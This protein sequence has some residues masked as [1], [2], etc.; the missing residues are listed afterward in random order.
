MNIITD[1]NII[2]CISYDIDA[3]NVGKRIGK[4]WSDQVVDRKL[5][6]LPNF[7]LFCCG[8]IGTMRDYI[9]NFTAMK[10]IRVLYILL[11]LSFSMQMFPAGNMNF[12]F[13]KIQV[14]EGLSEN[15][16][17]C[18]LQDSK[19]F[20]W[21]G[22]KDGLNRYDG[23]NFR[24]FRHNVLN[25]SSLGNNFIRSMAEGTDG[26][27]Y[28]GTD[29]GLYI[30]DTVH[31]TFSF[32]AL[33]TLEG[34][35]LTTAVN[36]LFIDKDG[37]LWIGS[38]YQGTF[39]Y[40]PSKQTLRQVEV[41]EHNLGQNAV[42]TI[43]G[44]RS[45]TIWVGTRLG[46][47][48]YNAG[49]KELEAVDGLFSPLEN[50]D[51]EVL[52]I[53][54]DTKGCLWLGTWS[55][56]VRFYDRQRYY[57]TSY[58]GLQSETDYIT[59]VRALYQYDN[60]HI[61]IGSD[62]GLY[63]FD[64]DTKE[65]RR[66][67][68][69]QSHYSMSDQNVYS[70]ASDREGGIWIGTYFGGINYLDVFLLPVETYYA[71]VKHGM[72]SG[73]A[74]SQF[75]ED[76]K[77][78]MWI[79]TE[80]G[81]INYFD[82]RTKL[83]TQPIRTSYH[84]THAL[85]LDEDNLW[86]GT[87]SRGIDVYNTR[88]G[89]LVNYR[90]NVR[91]E[92]T[93]NDDCIFSLYRTKKGDIYAGTPVGLNKY[94]RQAD[95]F[96]RIN[97]VSGFIYDVKEDD[98]G[99][100]WVATYGNGVVRLDG[101]TKKWIYYDQVI[102]SDDPVVGS[103]LTSIYIDGQKRLI[104]SSE[105]RG[106]FI[107]DYQTDRFRNISETEGLPNNVVYGVLDDPFGNLWLSCNK[108]IVCLDVQTPAIHKVYNKEDG[109]QSNQFNYKSSYKTRD[110]K[111]YFGGI[112]GFSCFYPQDISQIQN[113]H[114]PSVEITDVRL[115]GN[116]RGQDADIQIL[117]NKQQR[118][119]FPY[120]K[121]SFTISY[122]SLSYQ[123][124]GKNE[125][126]YMLEGV[127]KDW[128]HAGNNK[129]VTYV[130]LRPG[131]YSF[132]VKASNNSGVWNEEGA[133]IDIEILP[134]F[135][136]SLPAKLLYLVLSI[137]LIY[138]L[139]S[140]F[141]K[142]HKEKQTQ[143]LYAYKTE[144]EKLAFKSKIDFFTNIAHE[145]RTPVSLIKAPLEEVV[146][147]G[148]GSEN[149][150]Q[151]LSVIEKNCNRLSVLI[152]QLL[153]FRKMD[154]IDYH[155]NPEE[156]DLK[157]Y[158]TELYE[159]FRKTA[160]SK[161]IEFTLSL[162]NE[163]LGT[164]VFDSDVLTKIT[165][166]LL[167][168]AM[169]FTRDKIILT[170]FANEDRSYT[171]T[172]EDNGKG[173]PNDLKKLVF[174]P[175]YQVEPDNNKVGTGIG[176]SLVKKLAKIV[177]GKVMV[178]DSEMGGALFSFT[179]SELSKALPEQPDVTDSNS[180]EAR[181]EEHAAVKEKDKNSI[182]VVDDNPDI[183]SFIKRVLEHDYIVD[184]ALDANTAWELLEKRGYDLIISDIM[185][186]DVDGISFT[187]RIKGDLNYS[188]IPVILL[189]AKT[190]NAVKIEGL[191]SGAEVFME[192][193][194]STS[195][196][197]AQI[198]SLLENRRTILEAF[199]RSPLASYSI[200][201]TNKG[202]EVFLSKLNEEIEKNLSDETFSVESLTDVL[203]I[204]RS[205]LQRKLKAICGVSPGEYLRN[206]RLKRACKLLLEGD[207]R[208]NE[209]AYYVGFSSASYFA[210]VFIKCYDMSPKEFIRRNSSEPDTE[211]RENGSTTF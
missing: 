138:I 14:D 93:L 83:I 88:T 168:N 129:S 24:V 81:G 144:Q 6:L 161:D 135:W 19:G 58:L 5:L 163:A 196:L 92:S 119:V 12:R 50:S 31:E 145:I 78:N 22:T 164:I 187:K 207:L 123:S 49:I 71:D 173:I 40:D 100:L 109:L 133:Q 80:D 117:L 211:E 84:N 125:Y 155:L 44:D 66:I 30:M 34:K 17:Y 124:Q 192:K 148:E 114:I 56:G 199:N 158:I 134:P 115:L 188:H 45:G 87:F 75:C 178:N 98:L 77:G 74:V 21:F 177:N 91:D 174:D 105:G 205:N 29:I 116:S 4:N 70:I 82:T 16:V 110:G 159:R 2:P 169:K 55:D 143:Q 195:F 206:Y 157:N 39:T 183:T 118:I 165:G 23:S 48:R 15:T 86:I 46:L 63:L 54:E 210:K 154:S 113:K 180:V 142:K 96:V 97:E 121:S 51:H 153:D 193:P 184:T 209:V 89:K 13:R 73:K 8:A 139:I 108:G 190:E 64:I 160:V 141:W 36:S 61:L 18:I 33:E 152:N 191:R 147:S 104:F 11:L 72:L 130:N 90:N 43:Y 26:V 136:L 156:V 170:M 103:K 194:F 69:P 59:H 106:I 122:I 202:D 107:Y 95:R 3:A 79:A 111:F 35:R 28:I 126:A 7:Y 120:Y 52:T 189:S 94:D 65:G 208:I 186:P 32:V 176:L 185:M 200:L 10:R 172:V 101:K 166:N 85:L 25:P 42:W 53:L 179:F 149:T 140:Y 151:N 60:T 20:M 99:N 132:K 201:A 68:V 182:L 181:S 112:N 167:T 204:S 57:N 203:G 146:A 102:S 38:M 131:E 9:C 175:F 41:K 197:K 47:L 171:I 128:T 76:A 27:L 37:V 127:D 137:A 62:D 150:K 198:V 1:I 162:P 67:D